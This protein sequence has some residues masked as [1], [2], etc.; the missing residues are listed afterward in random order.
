[1]ES[2]YDT[3]GLSISFDTEHQWLYVEWKGLHDAASAQSGGEVILDLLRTR[4]CRRML[5]DN[6]EVVGD[7]EKSAR[8]VGSYYYQQLADLGVKYVAW[9]CPPHWPARKS[10]DAAMQFVSRPMVAIFEDLAS[11]YFWLRRQIV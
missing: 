4:P 9:V 8:W 7:W 10:M 3:P 5:N 2:L 11:A 1:M 6:S